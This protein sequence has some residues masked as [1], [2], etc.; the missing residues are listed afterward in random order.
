MKKY[1]H[2]SV[3]L[4]LFLVSCTKDNGESPLESIN[5]VMTEQE[6][7][8]NFAKIL[9]KAMYENEQLREFIKQ[10]ALRKYD[11]DY[12]VFY[13]YVKDECLVSGITFREAL[14]DV[15]DSPEE[16]VSIE[17]QCPK[18]TIL[19]PDWSWIGSFSAYEWDTSKNDILVGYSQKGESHTLYKNGEEYLAL[20]LGEIPETPTVIIKENERMKVISPSTKGDNMVY[21]FVDPY[22]DGGIEPETKGRA[23]YEDDIELNYESISNF[24]PANDLDTLLLGA[25]REFGSGYHG[26]GCQRDYIYYGMTP[27]IPVDGICNDYIRERFYRFKINP[28]SYSSISQDYDPHLSDPIDVKGRKNQLSAEEL[29]ERIWSDGAFEFVFD[30]YLG[31]S[32]VMPTSSSATIRYTASASEVFDLT[33]VHRRYKHQTA[34][35]QG[36]YVYS[37]LKENLVPK[38]IY[39]DG[40]VYLPKWDISSSSNNVFISA[41]EYDET[42]TKTKTEDV[43][44]TYSNN[45]TFNNNIE[46]GGTIVGVTLKKTL[47]LSDAFNV[48]KT[49]NN[50]IVIQT[51]TSSDFLGKNELPYEGIIVEGEDT[52]TINGVIREGYSIRPVDFGLFSITFLP[53]D[54]RN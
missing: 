41:Q 35:A 27:E 38:W 34:I 33:K 10:N 39:I 32:G 26:A 54:I 14:I 52:M 12:D 53:V 28:N 16:L 9:S 23:W 7:H 17:A 25:Y 15:C 45:F 29:M 43:T 2:L 3:F 42:E 1:L 48:Q 50:K 44:F 37:F 22:F 6:A 5:Y 36:E 4:A 30:V 18:L 13:P 49:E 8:Q 11:K 31:T 24:V 20:S 51:T 40:N 47:G 21:D 19:V 46:V